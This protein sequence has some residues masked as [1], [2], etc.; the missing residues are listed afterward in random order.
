MLQIASALLVI[1]ASALVCAS[2]DC[3]HASVVTAPATMSAAIFVLLVIALGPIVLLRR[4]AAIGD[5]SPSIE[6]E[7]PP[8][9]ELWNER[10]LLGVNQLTAVPL[11]HI[12]ETI[13][14]R[15][16]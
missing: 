15:N 13:L 10:T 12:S 5:E 14:W 11:F 4:G 2:R 3:G 1:K 6:S 8:I 7:N 16:F 9:D